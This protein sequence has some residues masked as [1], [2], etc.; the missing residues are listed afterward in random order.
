ML[1]GIPAF[2]EEA[3]LVPLIEKLDSLYT[4]SGLYLK[5]LFVDDGSSDRT[6]ELLL[7]ARKTRPYL[8]VITHPQNQG[9]GAAVN[10][11]LDYADTHLADGDVLVTMDGDNTHDPAYVPDMVEMLKQGNLDLVVASRF[12]AG[13]KELG[14]QSYRKLLSRGASLFFRV[15]FRIPGLR[16]YSSG[17]RAYSMAFL[18]RA[19]AQ[20]GSLVTVRGFECMAEILAKS[21]RLNPKA[22]EYPLVLHYEN[23]VGQSKM[24]ILRTIAG[25]V[26]LL[27]KAG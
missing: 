18:H 19:M 22:A 25:Y 23:K 14:L 24:R 15:F 7:T 20:W 1:I 11:I 17:Y 2:N 16:D 13:G 12:V 5:L 9:L 3:S 6:G 4:L 8:Q 21:R 26:R 10:T 27:R